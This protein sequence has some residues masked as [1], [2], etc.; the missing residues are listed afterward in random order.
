MIYLILSCV[1][2][3]IILFLFVRILLGLAKI[4]ARD[5]Y[6][7]EIIL[8]AVLLAIYITFQLYK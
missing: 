8:F 3:S 1:M 2:L 4:N 7:W 5:I 6:T